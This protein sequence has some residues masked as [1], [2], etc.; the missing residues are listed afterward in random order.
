MPRPDII[1][2]TGQTLR[3]YTLLEK[4]A[5]GSQAVVY[6]ACQD[7]TGKIFAVKILLPEYTHHAEFA[8]RFEG[9]VDSIQRI[10]HH[11]YI[12]PM[13]E[14]W[15]GDEGAVLVLRWFAGGSLKDCLAAKGAQSAA[16]VG[17]LLCQMA[18]VLHAAHGVGVIHRDVKPENILLD[19][20]CTAH[21]GD[22][23]I[24][25][26]SNANITS[27]GMML[28]SPAYLSPE[29]LMSEPIT[30]RTD[31][32]ALG[33]TLYEALLGEHPYRGLPGNQIMLRIIRQTLPPITSLRPDLPESLDEFFRIAT[34]Y[35][36]RDRY[37][38]MPTM[39]AA[40]TAA[41]AAF[42]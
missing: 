37:A 16:F 25:K 42:N 23:G 13:F 2:H 8:Q 29:Q 27:I 31:G 35:D 24:A 6:R 40:F 34:A 26:R 32:Y 30:E 22:F 38:D 15:R 41:T 4:V 36:P 10:N 18:D 12:V 28:G 7:A 20:T 3:G 39:A 33:V 21:L 5:T 11:P 17:K 9:E 1:D 19:E 14:H